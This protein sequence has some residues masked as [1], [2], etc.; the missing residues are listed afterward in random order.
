MTKNKRFVDLDYCSEIVDRVTD[1]RYSEY[2]FY[3]GEITD[4]LNELS[5]RGDKIH[6]LYT[7]RELLSLRW[8]KDI[9]ERF[10]REVLKILMK[11]NIDSL[12]KL[13][14]VLLNERTW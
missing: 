1:K 3:T 11:Y 8:Q 9:Y 10:S 6:E 13:D 7:T 2:E 14:Q 5:D 4:L 12:E